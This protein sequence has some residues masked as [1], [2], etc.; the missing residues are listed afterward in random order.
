MKRYKVFNNKEK[1]WV[2]DNV[3]IAPNG[4]IFDLRKMPF[5]MVKMSKAKDE[6]Y[7]IYYSTDVFDMH[8]TRIYEGD[9]CRLSE[10]DTY[11]VV[12]YAEQH[13]SYYLFDEK[14]ERYYPLNTAACQQIEV[15]G[16]V[17]QTHGISDRSYLVKRGGVN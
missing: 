15:V 7:T 1:H 3:Y 6:K 13:A 14:N 8:G 5:G 10:S 4:D 17:R 2:K 16:H 9:I 11:G 12:A